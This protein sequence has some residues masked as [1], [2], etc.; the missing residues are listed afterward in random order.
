MGKEKNG[1]DFL[2]AFPVFFLPLCL[3]VPR[4]EEKPVAEKH[5]ADVAVG[6]MVVGR[7]RKPV[8]A[9]ML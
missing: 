1:C 6:R 2:Q 3:L 4:C 9:E 8:L 7:S 5:T